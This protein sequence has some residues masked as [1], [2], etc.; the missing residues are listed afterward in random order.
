MSGSLPS[1]QVPSTSTL[2]GPFAWNDRPSGAPLP[3][4]LTSFVGRERE[5]NVVTELL[6]QPDVRLLTLTGTGG[7]G[8]TRLALHVA[9]E[10]T[11]DFAHGVRFVPLASLRNSDLVAAAVAEALSLPDVPGQRLVRR[12]QGFL[13]HRRM[14]LVFDNFEHLLEAAPLVHDLLATCPFL[15]ILCTSRTRLNISGEHVFTVPTLVLP[16]F[17]GSANGEN[18][19]QSEAVRLFVERA[20]ASSS[21]FACTPQNV[22]EVSEI[23]R[24]LDGLPLAIELAAARVSVLSLPALLARLDLRLNL[25]IDGPRDAPT[26]QRT[27]RDSIAWSHDLLTSDEQ[28]L[29]RRL[30]VFSG[31]CSLDAVEAVAVAPGECPSDVFESIASLVKQTLLRQEDGVGTNSRYVMLETVRE[32]AQERLLAS[33]EAGD[34]R[35]RHATYI[36]ALS[37]SRQSGMREL[38]WLEQIEPEH[39]NIRAVLTWAIERGDVDTAQRLVA[40]IW[41]HFW[42]IRGHF[43]EGR[44]W[45]ERVRKLGP[46]SSLELLEEVL[47]AVSAFA[48]SCGDLEHAVALAHEAVAGAQASGNDVRMGMAL[49]HLAMAI[50]HRDGMNKAEPII[51]RART[52]MN[53]AEGYRERRTAAAAT[54]NLA[55]AVG[56]RGDRERAE[57]LASEALVRWQEI[58]NAWG[59]AGTLTTLASLA[60][61]RGDVAGAASLG[62]QA[63]ALCWRLGSK[64]LLVDALRMAAGTSPTD[65]VHAELMVRIWSAADALNEDLGLVTPPEEQAY[66]DTCLAQVRSA[67]RPEVFAAAWAAGRAQPLKQIVDEALVY[68]RPPPPGDASSVGG[69]GAHHGLTPRELEILCHLAERRTDQ[70][71][72]DVL[73]LSRR[74]VNAHVAHVLAKLS[75]PTRRAAVSRARELNII[76]R[77]DKTRT[78]TYTYT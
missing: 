40:A 69:H 63:L 4:P 15:K 8:K 11:D 48:L 71:I 31:G 57:A 25:L 66:T 17:I 68:M 12:L 28:R 2:R 73:F 41:L 19:F 29:Y 34:V 20:T 1:E 43:R 70:E 13:A 76:P 60:L 50:G 59:T 45:A 14:L 64:V 65:K 32:D 55:V 42:A 26:R 37:E 75:A 53:G 74:T 3:S 58:S 77:V 39:D 56:R 36:L 9:S 7:I 33:G 78:Y 47:F 46:G 24:C 38:E 10:P 23:C 51:E 44:M 5:I 30:A 27:M 52:L 16:H 21:E 18:P 67:L 54:H 61:E 22:L 62:K 49:H 6:L 72:A 35:H